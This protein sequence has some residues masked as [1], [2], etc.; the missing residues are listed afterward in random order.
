MLHPSACVPTSS[1]A[2]VRRSRTRTEDRAG[3]QSGID[4][5]RDLLVLARS[6]APVETWPS[7]GARC[8]SRCRRRASS[9]SARRSCVSGSSVSSGS[10]PTCWTQF[11]NMHAPERHE[12]GDAERGDVD[13]RR[14]APAAARDRRATQHRNVRCRRRRRTGARSLARRQASAREPSP[15]AREQRSLRARRTEE[16]GERDPRVSGFPARRGPS[17]RLRRPT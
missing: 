11:V 6:V 5:M 1:G 2:E 14:H 13:E 4:V 10:Q 17:R 8:G 7:R 9:S 16:V 15:V 12:R 3:V